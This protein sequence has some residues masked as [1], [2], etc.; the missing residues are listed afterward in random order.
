MWLNAD[1]PSAWSKGCLHT[2]LKPDVEEGSS[3]SHGLERQ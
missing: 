3:K 2:S 1:V